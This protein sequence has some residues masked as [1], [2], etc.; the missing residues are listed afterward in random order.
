MSSIKQSFIESLFKALMASESKSTEQ[1]IET[2]QNYN[3][4]L[5]SFKKNLAA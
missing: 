1:G 2:T 3:D 4:M 5:A